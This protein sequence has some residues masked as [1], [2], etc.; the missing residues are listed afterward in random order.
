MKIVMES[1]KEETS[2]DLS[3]FTST[4]VRNVASAFGALKL[5]EIDELPDSAVLDNIDVLKNNTNLSRKQVNIQVLT[6]QAYIIKWAG[7]SATFLTVWRQN[8]KCR[9]SHKMSDQL[10]AS[11]VLLSLEIFYFLSSNPTVNGET[12]SLSLSSGNIF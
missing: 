5:K 8:F 2:K 12:V 7:P 3:E 11:F 4:D 6:I 9:N 10:V 1:F